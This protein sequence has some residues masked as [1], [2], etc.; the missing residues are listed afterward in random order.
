MRLLLFAVLATVFFVA[1][2]GC[3]GLIVQ[4][5]P[6]P[7]PTPAITPVAPGDVSENLTPVPGSGGTGTPRITATPSDTLVTIATPQTG[8]VR[9]TPTPELIK[10]RLITKTVL[11]IESTSDVEWSCWT[12]AGSRL[13]CGGLVDPQDVLSGRWTCG[14]SQDGIWEC[15]GNLDTGDLL[16]ERWVCK[17]ATPGDWICSGDI[18]GSDA[19]MERWSCRL[20]S[21]GR[22]HCEGDLDANPERDRW[23]C[24]KGDILWEC[25]QKIGTLFPL[26]VPVIV[27][28]DV[29]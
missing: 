29:T 23:T 9:V 20:S 4:Q 2:V 6:T 11:R 22:W 10:A 1:T 3:E 13:R 24:N 25:S 19:S 18:D 8:R 7:T 12:D 28:S 14:E 21:D 16:D 26:M 15:G 5:T 27:T 17:S